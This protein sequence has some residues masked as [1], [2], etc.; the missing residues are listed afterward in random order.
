MMNDRR[1]SQA[2]PLIPDHRNR[3]RLRFWTGGQLRDEVWLDAA[4]PE[5]GALAAFVA[6]YHHTLASNAEAHG[7]GWLSEVFDPAAPE[8]HAYVRFGT[9]VAGMIDPVPMYWA[10]G[11]PTPRP[12]NG[13]G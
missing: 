7:V 1:R 10:N 6:E 5:S 9:D 13:R 11:W 12:P 8:E 2:H 4:D 3:L